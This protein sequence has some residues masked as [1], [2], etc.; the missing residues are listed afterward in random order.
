MRAICPQC[1]EGYDDPGGE[2]PRCACKL[3]RM[4]EGSLVG[5][6]LDGK[7]IVTKRL[8]RGATGNIYRARHRASESD[9][10]IKVLRRDRLDS[11]EALARFYREVGIV[12]QLSHSNIVTIF[13]FG[14]A[15][16]GNEGRLYIAME[17]LEGETLAQIMSDK[18]PLEFERS[19]RIVAQVADALREAHAK[20]VIHRD[21][22]PSNIMLIEEF[23]E[24]DHVKVLDFGVAKILA[25]TDNRPLTT[26]TQIAGAAAYLSPEQIRSLNIDG[27]ADLYGLAMVLFTMLTGKP[28]FRG[29][30]ITSTLMKHITESI[31]QLD[32]VNPDLA[33]P[34][35]IDEF[36]SR[37]LA[38]DPARRIE[39]AATFK[40][41]VLELLECSGIEH[42]DK[43]LT[44]ARPP[45]SRRAA[46]RENQPTQKHDVSGVFQ[47]IDETLESQETVRV[48]ISERL[49]S[50]R[51]K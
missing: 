41:E 33:Y 9:V 35:A 47:A 25:P 13:D 7:Y 39:D 2:C 15:G 34:S 50:K 51:G 3:E 30:D 29:V 8:G 16:R 28:A 38:K 5:A 22:N 6:E 12:S 48:D 10:A 18:Q 21:I 27:R 46:A 32:D 40:T 45:Q 36:F 43:T 20:D 23:G 26:Q 4:E 42:V 49:P 17:L 44:D 19:V 14:A 37:A 31:P 11:R 24:P 1:T